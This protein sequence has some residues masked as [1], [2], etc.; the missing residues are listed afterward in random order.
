MVP[1]YKPLRMSNAFSNDYIECE[2][3]GD[4]NKTLLI[5]EYLKE[6]K[7]YLSIMIND[8]KALSKFKTQESINCTLLSCHVRC[9]HLNFRYRAH[10]EN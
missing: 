7:I 10:F 5:E 8:L 4:K 2:I 6:I 1:Y 9:C 3:I